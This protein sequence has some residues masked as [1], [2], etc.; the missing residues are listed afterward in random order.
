MW[1]ALQP[2][3]PQDARPRVVMVY[4]E[5][6]VCP[7]LSVEANVLLGQESH[8]WVSPKKTA[9]VAAA[10]AQLGHGD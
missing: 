4:Q 8:A 6:A 1:T 7:D 5:L 9:R 2:T 10:L 3:G